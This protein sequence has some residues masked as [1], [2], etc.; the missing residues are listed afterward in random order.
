ML[1]RPAKDHR[2][3]IIRNINIDIL[4][5]QADAYRYRIGYFPR[6]GWIDIDGRDLGLETMI[7]ANPALIV[8]GF[9]TEWHVDTE[10]DMQSVVQRCRP[11]EIRHKRGR[12]AVRTR[13]GPGPRTIKYGRPKSRG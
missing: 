1:S 8:F 7:T 3:E 5:A 12:T 4:I 6:N 13:S 2:I 9:E 11:V 10:T